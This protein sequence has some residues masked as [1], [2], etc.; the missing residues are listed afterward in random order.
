MEPVLP[1]A[2]TRRP[3]A[4]LR[5]IR[6]ADAEPLRSVGSLLFDSCDARLARYDLVG[7]FGGGIAAGELFPHLVSNQTPE[8]VCER[9]FLG[10]GSRNAE[11]RRKAGLLDP[12]GRSS[13]QLRPR[14]RASIENGEL[15]LLILGRLTETAFNLTECGDADPGSVSDIAEP[16]SARHAIEPSGRNG[17]ASDPR[18]GRVRRGR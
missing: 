17:R 14:A 18:G 2:I 10:A 4:A 13:L 12:I 8:G 11:A 15:L 9:T 5:R 3:P 16:E 7:I 1:A 6:Y